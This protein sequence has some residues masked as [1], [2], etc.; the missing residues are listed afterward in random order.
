MKAGGPGAQ[1]PGQVLSRQVRA[2]EYQCAGGPAGCHPDAGGRGSPELTRGAPGVGWGHSVTSTTQL[3]T[4]QQSSRLPFHLPALFRGLPK[5]L[6][7]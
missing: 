7:G 5:C 3:L 4:H 6:S 2:S 1:L